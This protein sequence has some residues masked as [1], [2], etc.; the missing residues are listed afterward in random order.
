MINVVLFPTSAILLISKGSR[1]ESIMRLKF[2]YMF[3]TKNIDLKFSGQHAFVRKSIRNN[4]LFTLFCTW[5]HKE[6][7]QYIYAML[8]AFNLA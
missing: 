6:K 2:F 4:I 8:H 7:I 1:N 3:K 5:L